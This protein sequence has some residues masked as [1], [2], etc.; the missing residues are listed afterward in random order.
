MVANSFGNLSYKKN[1]NYIERQIN[2]SK[3]DSVLKPCLPEMFTK[4]FKSWQKV[5][6]V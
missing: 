1:Y 6:V 5:A 3:L 4:R 2:Q